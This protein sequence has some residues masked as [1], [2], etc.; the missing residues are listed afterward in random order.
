ML[1][2]AGWIAIGF[3]AG[4]VVCFL[5]MRNNVKFMKEHQAQIEALVLG[6]QYTA[7]QIV[8]KIRNLLKI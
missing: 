3:V 6:G 8:A 1:A 2:L 4:A 7:E 5:F